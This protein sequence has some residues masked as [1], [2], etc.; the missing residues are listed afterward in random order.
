LPN[1]AGYAL[2][3]RNGE[4]II[5]DSKDSLKYIISLDSRSPVVEL[6]IDQGGIISLQLDGIMTS[7]AFDGK[8]LWKLESGSYP[9]CNS[10][11]G[12]N[13]VYVARNNSLLL[14]DRTKGNT[15]TSIPYTLSAKALAFSNE[16]NTVFLALSWNNSDGADSIVCIKDGKVIARSGFPGMRISSNLS[17]TGEKHGEIAFGYFGEF[18]QGGSV[19]KTFFGVFG[20]IAD[21]KPIQKN[22]AELPYIV[23][24]IAANGEL[25][26]ASGF[27]E[28]GG[29]LVSGMDCFTAAKFEKRW[30]RRFSEPLI[31]PVVA[32]QNNVYF[33]LSFSTA[34]ETP[35][36]GLFYVLSTN[37]GKTEQEV[38]VEGARNGFAPGMPMPFGEGA[39]MLTDRD[40][41]IVYFIRP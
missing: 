10:L 18:A 14:L 22:K 35:S 25:L 38:S 33:T 4:V 19:R 28:Y 12:G 11:V 8:P 39:L 34:A 1:A 17:L 13:T 2:G 7:L 9:N 37:D 24:N 36:A 40:N 20:G 21:G 16:S 27:R 3:T 26:I 41:P 30:Q 29:E 6:L 23:M 5:F 31:T 32:S 15:I